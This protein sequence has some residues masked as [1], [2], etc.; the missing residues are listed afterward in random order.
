MF[1]SVLRTML[2]AGVTVVAEAAFQ[3]KLWPSL[4]PLAGVADIRV[5]AALSAVPSPMSGSSAG[6]R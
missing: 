5:V 6:P 3:D 4:E 1:F 2:E